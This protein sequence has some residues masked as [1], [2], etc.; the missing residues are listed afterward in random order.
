MNDP[1]QIDFYLRNKRKFVALSIVS[2]VLLAVFFMVAVVFYILN[3]NQRL[4]YTSVKVDVV[5]V[6][7]RTPLSKTDSD[8]VVVTYNGQT[9]EVNHLRTDEVAKYQSHMIM[10]TPADAY[11]ANGKLYSNVD[12]VRSGTVIGTVYF[13]FL[14]GTMGLIFTTAVLIGCVVEAKKREKGIYPKKYVDKHGPF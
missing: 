12:G 13:V 10:N 5:S 4:S 2:G 9:Y 3:Q 7:S 6:H 1:K 8:K 11:L 14:F